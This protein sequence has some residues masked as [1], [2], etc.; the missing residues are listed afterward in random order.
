MPK[1]YRIMVMILACAWSG[2]CRGT[3]ITHAA[4]VDRLLRHELF[5]VHLESYSYG[6]SEEIQWASRETCFRAG[7]GSFT[8]KIF[9][10][11]VDVKIRHPLNKWLTFKYRWHHEDN[12]LLEETDHRAALFLTAGRFGI[13]VTGMAE[14]AKQGNDVGGVVSYREAED[15]WI[16][17]SYTQLD[18][19]HNMKTLDKGVYLD[20][21]EQY[22]M[23]LM[24]RFGAAWAMAGKLR[25]D[26]AWAYRDRDG[27][28]ERYVRCGDLYLEREGAPWCMGLEVHWLREH[29]DRF[30]A[31]A[32]MDS[33]NL[34]AVRVTGE[35]RY[36]VNRW[37]WRYRLGWAGLH[38]NGYEEVRQRLTP[39]LENF[40]FTRDDV[41][42]AVEVEAALG[43][44]DRVAVGLITGLVDIA[45]PAART[46]PALDAV[47]RAKVVGEYCHGFNVAGDRGD[48]V[49]LMS[50]NV[51]ERRFGGGDARL[52]FWL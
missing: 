15:H 11:D 45:A 10:L 22:R 38:G 25:W 29:A 42:T 27:R 24:W 12:R 32:R 51:T 6:L 36:D 1:H 14:G 37:C 31:D 13:G 52:V 28:Q 39:P 9:L 5:F 3:F 47:I 20:L 46:I 43:G 33:L 16:E 4:D 7:A 2:A 17:A 40:R 26:T 44:S 23:A 21:P 48:L 49:L 19:M 34:H 8:S 50:Y 41:L 18:C 35:L 30:A